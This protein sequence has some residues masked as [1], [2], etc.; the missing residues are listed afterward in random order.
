MESTRPRSP[1]APGQ[2]P[3][4][5]TSC[6]TTNKTGFSIFICEIETGTP[7]GVPY[8]LHEMRSYIKCLACRK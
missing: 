8:G 5:T 3:S 7:T 2:N 4:S 6:G 1:Q